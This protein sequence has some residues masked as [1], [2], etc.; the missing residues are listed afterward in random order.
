[1]HQLYRWQVLSIIAFD[2]LHQ[3]RGR[4]VLCGDRGD[5]VLGVSGT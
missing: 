2:R 3:L 4:Q 5:R 1:V